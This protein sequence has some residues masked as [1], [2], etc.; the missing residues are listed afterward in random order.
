MGVAQEK[1]KRQEKKRIMEAEISHDLPSVSGRPGRADG[2]DSS[3][4]LKAGELGVL[5]TEVSIVR[6]K[7]SSTFWYLFVQFSPQWIR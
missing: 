7:A 3:L 1:T 4:S 6:Q 5:E 2:V